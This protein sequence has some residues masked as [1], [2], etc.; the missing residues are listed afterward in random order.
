MEEWKVF[1]IGNRFFIPAWRKKKA[2][3]ILITGIINK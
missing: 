1:Q 2:G 3:E